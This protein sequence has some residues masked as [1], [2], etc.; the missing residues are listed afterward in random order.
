MSG[1]PPP[2][3][4]STCNARGPPHCVDCE[5][6]FPGSPSPDVS[7]ARAC[8]G[9]GAAIPPRRTNWKAMMST[10]LPPRLPPLVPQPFDGAKHGAAARANLWHD[11][12]HF[13][14][15]V[16]RYRQL[17][18]SKGIYNEGGRGG[19]G[20]HGWWSGDFCVCVVCCV[21]PGGVCCASRVFLVQW[22]IDCWLLPFCVCF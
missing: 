11:F 15:F 1:C 18:G 2:R 9:K 20:G 22:I 14:D 12:K 3:L 19:W 17:P 10:S 5:E 7:S 13:A 6:L 4:L 21:V 8:R 16:T